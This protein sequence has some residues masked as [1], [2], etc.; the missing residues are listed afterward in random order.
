MAAR[1]W[2]SWPGS[3]PPFQELAHPLGTDP[4]GRDVLA[5]VVVGGKISLTVGIFSV[6]GR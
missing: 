6:L 1:A 4:L 5:R 2:T 3:S